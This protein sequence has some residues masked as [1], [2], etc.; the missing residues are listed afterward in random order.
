[1]G[2]KRPDRHRAKIKEAET[3]RGLM[4]KMGQSDSLSK[5]KD[6]S[7]GEEEEGIVIYKSFPI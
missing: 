7:K 3:G 5:D 2:R 4:S 1:M 6:A